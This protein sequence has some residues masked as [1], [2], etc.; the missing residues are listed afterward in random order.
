VKLAALLAERP[1]VLLDFDGPMCAVFGGEL[2]APEAARRLA[3]AARKSGV[4]LDADLNAADDP[5][6][7]LHAAAR[8]SPED[9]A[10]VEQLL[11]DAEVRAVS[12]API[13]DG[14]LAML[15]ALR[16]SG[17]STTVVSNNSDAAV[18]AF[19]AAHD[20][21]GLIRG[22]VARTEPDPALLKPNPHLVERA[23]NENHAQPE[24]CVLVGD[25]TTDVTAA[26]EAGTSAI[27]YANKP[28]KRDALTALHPAAV[29]THLEDLTQAATGPVVS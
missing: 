24:R 18:R 26:H 13:T 16:D 19:L 22:V 27:G 11:R 12:T 25:S 6:D 23:I 8:N 14:L 15:S 2:S 28:G 21:H 10:Q 20:L 1:V 9:A 29:I 7:V 5:F 3:Q 17:H 4:R